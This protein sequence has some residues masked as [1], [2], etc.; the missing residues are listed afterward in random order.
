MSVANFEDYMEQQKKRTKAQNDA[1]HVYCRQLAKALN[2]AGYS[3]DDV[4]T[5]PLDIPWSEHTVKEL[6][7]HRVQ[8]ALTN[9]KSTTQLE[10]QEITE[11]YEAVNRGIAQITGVSVPFP[12]KD[13]EQ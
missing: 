2:S 6:I 13:L 3:V 5:K 12:T 9:K 7:W 1:L 4:I 10:K 11:I 8:K